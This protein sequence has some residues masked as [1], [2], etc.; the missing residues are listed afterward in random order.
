MTILLLILIIGVL[1]FVHELGHFVVAKIF[2]IRVDEFGMGLPPRAVKIFSRKGTDYTL[3]WIPF[4][5]FVKIYGENALD[6]TEKDDPDYEKS[7][8]AKKWWQQIA[9]LIAGVTMNFLLAWGLFALVFMSGAPTVVSR[10]DHESVKDASFTV[11]QV[12]KDSPADRAGLKSGE[13]ITQIE[14]LN[15]VV[16]GTELHAESF[17]QSI[18]ST[19][20]I[21]PVQISVMNLD[22]EVREVSILPE[23]KSSELPP[24]IGVSADYVGLYQEG[25]FQSIGSGL[26]QTVFVTKETSKAFVRLIGDAFQGQADMDNLT[27]P[28]GLVS[29]V[30]D[31]QKV[32]FSYVLMLAATISVNLAVLNLF[33]FPALDGGRIVMVII[34]TITRRK[35]KPSIVQW[36]N[37]IGFLLLIGLMIIITVKDVIKLF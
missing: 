30:G 28:V 34:E 18:R 6:E 2:G 10:A 20:G 32:G 31:A 36:V 16:S 22:Q 25:F 13:I 24:M 21:A 15:G 1:I 4:G 7:F 8:V 29:V 12:V 9:V 33:P 19:E 26:S 17:V 23:R 27:G 11:L 37:G 35:I 14:T 5:G 3:N